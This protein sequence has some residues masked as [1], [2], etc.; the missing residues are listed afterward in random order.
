MFFTFLLNAYCDALDRFANYR[1][2]KA[3]IRRAREDYA[4]RIGYFAAGSPGY[5]K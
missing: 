4:R 1:K 5:W 2:R 3:D